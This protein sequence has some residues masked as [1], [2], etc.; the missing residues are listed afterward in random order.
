MIRIFSVKVKNK[1][2]ILAIDPS[3]TASGWALLEIDTGILL[4]SGVISPPGPRTI[5]AKRYEVL[6]EEV[7][8][9]FEMLKLSADFSGGAEKRNFLICEGPAPL[10]LNPQSSLKVERV[11]SIFEAVARSSG[12]EVPGRLN[13]RTVQTELL[14]MRGKQLPRTVVKA[15]ARETAYRLFGE[16][17]EKAPIFGVPEASQ[18]LPQDIVDALL[19][20]SLA[21]SKIQ[22]V[23]RLG[24]EP[25][26]AFS[27][28]A[29]GR[30]RQ[31]NKTVRWTEQAMRKA[32]NED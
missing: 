9:L 21:V 5:L 2:K 7:C 4:F 23:L 27:S 10:V 18:E 16:Q 32:L 19:I 25:R 29:G 13:P 26:E 31:S 20:G 15:W 1:R 24:G 28:A 8:Q 30:K 17:L 3:L 6:Q 12:I 22:H 14:G 11:R